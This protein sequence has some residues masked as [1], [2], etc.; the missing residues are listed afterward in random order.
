MTHL[1][2]LIT[3]AS[4]ALLLTA[5]TSTPIDTQPDESNQAELKQLEAE[6]EQ[7]EKEIEL[8]EQTVQE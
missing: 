7:L 8:L 1:K 3:L 6:V 5:C 2:K 4:I